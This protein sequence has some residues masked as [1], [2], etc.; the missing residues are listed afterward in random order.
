MND[1]NKF[2][3]YNLVIIRKNNLT[4]TGAKAT[5]LNREKTYHITIILQNS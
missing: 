3:I 2:I 4:V 5:N 1:I